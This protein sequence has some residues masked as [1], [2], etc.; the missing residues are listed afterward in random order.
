MAGDLPPSSSDTRLRLP[1][2][3]KLAHLHCGWGPRQGE[4]GHRR[5][6]GRPSFPITRCC[7]PYRPVRYSNDFVSA[8]ARVSCPTAF[9]AGNSAARRTFGFATFCT[10]NPRPLA[11][12]IG[13]GFPLR[14]THCVRAITHFATPGGAAGTQQSKITSSRVGKKRR[15]LR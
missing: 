1:A 4:G 9:S 11:P 14:A 8:I 10:L 15:W 5:K 7:R 6:A 3:D 2:A 13:R 12:R